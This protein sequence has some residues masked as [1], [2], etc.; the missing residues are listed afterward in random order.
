MR[1][2]VPVVL[3]RK[4]WYTPGMQFS[5]PAR[6]RKTTP[7]LAL[8]VLLGLLPLSGPGCS[9]TRPPDDYLGTMDGSQFYPF[10]RGADSG[11]AAGCMMPLLGYGAGGALMST[12]A[13]WFYLGT[14]SK[15]QLDAGNI[16]DPL[17]TPPQTAYVIDKCAPQGD[18][19]FDPR[20][21]NYLRSVQYPVLANAEMEPTDIAKYR[22]FHLVVSAAVRADKQPNIGCNDIKSEKS[23]QE[24]GGWDKDQRRWG[25]GD[26]LDLDVTPVTPEQL[27]AGLVKFKDWPMVNVASPVMGSPSA[28]KACPYATGSTARG[29]KYP[30]DPAATYQFPSGSWYRGLLGGYLD[31][32]DLPITMDPAACAAELP[33]GNHCMD[34]GPTKGPCYCPRTNDLY[35]SAG[36]ALQH[37][38]SGNLVID[39]KTMLPV[40][41]RTALASGS[42]MLT[43]GSRSRKADILFTFAALRGQDGFSPA[44]RLRVY[45]P[46]KVV[47]ARKEA[48]DVAP[49]PLCTLAELVASKDA[50]V[51][52]SSTWV[53]CLF[54]SSTSM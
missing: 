27:K 24:R 32:G 2:H 29:P 11:P 10:F 16:T 4:P 19:H 53:H 21:S 51:K 18:T 38:M 26:N 30:G 20:T 50:Q 47:C 37:D 44:C 35:V 3:A 45:D 28:Q 36:E 8:G 23:V 52:I 1:S 48:E 12:A 14:L 22:P 41:D 17:N 33:A 7:P 5:L 46:R 42:V 9:G 40:V 25:Q 15:T 34:M 49:R 31:G 6:F 54:P 39:P 43:D 13:P